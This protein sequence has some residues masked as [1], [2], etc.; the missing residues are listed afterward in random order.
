[1]ASLWLWVFVSAILMVNGDI[2][3]DFRGLYEVYNDFHLYLGHVGETTHDQYETES[4]GIEFDCPSSVAPEKP[5]SVH[6]LRPGDF[7]VIAAVGD[8][9]SVRRSYHSYMVEF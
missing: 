5:T 9:L 2:E 1:M 4:F 7:N 3:D 6:R 8:S